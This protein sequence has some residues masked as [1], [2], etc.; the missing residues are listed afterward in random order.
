[1]LSFKNYEKADAQKKQA[2]KLEREFPYFVTLVSLLASSGFGPYT[3]FQKIRE[4]DLLPLVK[5]ESI[6]ILKRIELLGAD[7]LIAIA[8]TKDRQAS[9]TFGEFLAGYVSA[10]QS[11]GNVVNY[12]KSKMESAFDSLENEEKRVVEK[13]NGVIHAWLTMQIVILAVFILLA[14]VGS[15]P[16]GNSSGSQAHSDPPYILLIFSPLM[17]AMFLKIVKNMVNAN[18]PELPAKKIIKFLVPGVLIVTILVLTNVL[19]GLHMDAYLLGAALIAG[20]IWPALK[21]KKIY[22]LNIDAE[23]AT[24]QIL[25]DITEARKA[26]MGPEKCIIRAC[27]RKDFKSF[28]VIAN[29]ISN[30]LEWGVVLNNIY[31]ALRKEI[32]NFQVL[33]SF[34]ILF[35][36]ISSG[37]GTVTSLDSLA[38]T[39]GKIH[40]I[41]KNKREE[42]KVYVMVGF[43]LII[44]TGFTTLLT[45]DSFAA[46]NQEK[47]LDK[48]QKSATNQPN[49]FLEKVA[50]ALIVQAWLSGLFIGKI[51]KGAYS[52]GFLYCI[53]LIVFTMISIA[54]IQTHLINISSMLMRS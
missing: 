26:G 20:S 47:N 54:M 31:D 46:I 11:G 24:P 48:T 36:I 4:I 18:I 51:T 33:I 10:I 28:N 16:M 43:M 6:K 45:I 7:P 23:R 8:E 1:M 39:S 34:K 35:E 50:I 21:F 53:L 42:L 41:E 17:S 37:G 3:I 25:R 27:K 29:S 9:R 40:D 44:V 14:S 38:N 49:P 19:S 15:N 30:K 13:L 32:G 5:M 2:K 12:L 22:Q 52:G